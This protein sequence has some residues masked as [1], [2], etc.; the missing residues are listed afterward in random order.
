MSSQPNSKQPR[1]PLA[2]LAVLAILALLGAGCDGA[3]AGTPQ[4]AKEPPAVKVRVREI[5][6]APIRDVL[7]LPGTTEA[8]HDVV[9]PAERDGRVDWI[10]PQEG[11]R[12]KAGQLVA[13]IDVEALGAALERAQAVAKLAAETAGRRESLG[14]RKVIPQEDIERAV[15]ERTISQEQLKEAKVHYQ[16]GFVRAPIDGVINKLFVD[17]GEWVGAGKPVAEI[18]NPSVIRINTNAPELDVRYLKEGQQALVKVDAYPDRTWVG[19]VDFVAFK[20][21]GATKTFQVRVVVD[22]PDG[23]IR[24][25]MIARAAFLRRTIEGALSV[26]LFSIVDKGG[27]RL[28]FVEKDGMA[29]AR[30]VEVGVIEQDQ[31]QITKGLKPGDRLIIAGHKEVEEGTKVAAQ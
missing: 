2:M 8:R 12:V 24:P 4:K 26:P 3:P 22:N 9:L 17:P 18:V 28:V 19:K 30:M 29:R 21:D 5:Q 13:K 16:K 15:T 1:R 27:E 31:V 6:P 14:R 25:G 10:G 20:A 7:V 11:E 23:A